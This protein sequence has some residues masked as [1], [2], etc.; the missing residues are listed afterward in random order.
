MS[1][2][3]TARCAAGLKDA[4]QVRSPRRTP[5]SAAATYSAVDF[6]YKISFA[7][8]RGR[9]E[10][11]LSHEPHLAAKDAQAHALVGEAI[12]DG[13]LAFPAPKRKLAHEHPV[14]V[15]HQPGNELAVQQR[16]NEPTT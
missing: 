13:H 5:R 12:D 2:S 15:V 14:S 9:G 6:Q 8:T 4:N 3:V 16:R 11:L 7:Q 1:E 10:T